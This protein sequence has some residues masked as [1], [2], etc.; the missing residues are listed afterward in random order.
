M[1]TFTPYYIFIMDKFINIKGAGTNNL[2]QIDVA[3]PRGQ[4]SAILGVCG[5][6]KNSLAFQTIYAE[7][8]LRYIESISPYVRQFLD[9]IEKPVVERIDGLPPAIAFKQKKPA[10]NPR[11]IVAT[12]L[13]IFDYLRILYAKIANFSCPACG[14]AVKQ[15]SIDEIITHIID[16]FPGKIEVCFQY[17]GDVA[18][19]VNR[20]YYFYLDNGQRKRIDPQVKDK[21][22]PVLIDRI[23][24]NTTNKSRLFEAV[25]KSI[26]FGNGTA[27]IFHEGQ[28]HL[29]SSDLYCGQC[30]VH[31]PAP[32]EHLFSFN[33]PKG[34]CPLCKGFGDIQEIDPHLVFDTTLTLLE[35]AVRPFNTPMTRLLKERM[36]AKARVRGI[37][38]DQP[39]SQL[40]PGTLDF[41]M[42]GSGDWQ[43]T[44]VKGYFDQ[45]RKK[46][47]KIQ[48][49]VLLSR[50]TSYKKC[51]RCHGS[52]FNETALAFSLH[53]KNIGQF[54]ELTIGEAHDAICNLDPQIYADKIS[55]DVFRDITARLSYLVESGLS[56]IELDRPSSTLSR[57]EYQR[58]NL[59]FILG[60]TL[61]DSLVIIDQPS[62]DLHPHDYQKL[63]KYLMD[64]KSNGN[65]V[66]LVEHNREIIRACDYILELGPQSG[67]NGGKVVF[68]GT[69]QEFFSPPPGAPTTVSQHCF[70]KTVEIE[71]APHHFTTW[72]EFENA[73][74]HN[75]KNID[76]K[77]P[78][79]A[80]TV[81][82]GVSGA[83]K[84]TL[85]YH[86]IYLK[87]QQQLTNLVR[88]CETQDIREV[89][90]IE[91]GLSGL[92][93]QT[94]TAGFFN[95]YPALRELFASQK[96]SQL[97]GYTPSH[98]SFNSALGRCESC[99]GK[100]YREIEMQFLPAVKVTCNACSGKGFNPE[101]LKIEYKSKNIREVLDMT[102]D[103]FIE[104]VEGEK[105]FPAKAKEILH[106]IASYGL[107]DIRLGQPL[108]TLSAGEL[109]RIKLLKYLHRKQRDTL[110]LVDEPCFG[111]HCSDIKTVKKLFGQII[112]N[113]GT[114]V[115]A[116]HNLDL[117]ASADYIIELGHQGGKNGG[118]LVYQGLLDGLETCPGSTTAHYLKKNKK[119]T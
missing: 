72:L 75:L 68:S 46:S 58:I 70:K 32:D 96:E 34:A 36:L 6:G 86:E 3:I 37:P 91:P 5:A 55:F 111:L 59:A 50:Y 22:I 43:F 21:T 62:C 53:G 1:V 119:N 12:S 116:E 42:D 9:K 112:E 95:F 54:L 84:T 11:S 94:I 24:V 89:V 110:F 107:G 83:G 57:G 38:L 82:T 14:T 90:F 30:D 17:Q 102:V 20:G 65:T 48:N 99:S 44:G 8:Y 15:F 52:R 85:L 66:L 73:A 88:G 41:L 77:I 100:G 33:S 80:F 87:Y 106:T 35:G 67:E 97:C 19:L 61:S 117:I 108:K 40:S 63:I 13:D 104:L 51:P 109:Q 56:Y 39:L 60:S 64:L 105:Q 4:I 113:G 69:R 23:E 28:K 18:F 78:L 47:Y 101:V 115:A 103:R 26:S 7:G 16:N 98:F 79:Q 49:R 2:D 92:K 76:F 25:D 71:K 31:Y 10:R 45:V 74:T 81:I 114:V 118:Y 29:F 93:S 27:L